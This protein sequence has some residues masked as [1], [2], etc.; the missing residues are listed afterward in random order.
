MSGTLKSI[1][2]RENVLQ[3]FGIHITDVERTGKAHIKFRVEYL[4]N[5]RIFVCPSSG[6]DC[7]R[8]IK[9]FKGDVTKWVKEISNAR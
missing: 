8:G 1:K 7:A 4:G 3:S 2:E 5:K 6:S 9:N